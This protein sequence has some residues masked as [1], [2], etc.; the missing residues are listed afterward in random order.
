MN[1]TAKVNEKKFP[2]HVIKV[3]RADDGCTAEVRSD[4]IVYHVSSVASGA[5]AFFGRA[6]STK[7]SYFRVT[8]GGPTQTTTPKTRFFSSLKTTTRKERSISVFAKIDSEEV[9]GKK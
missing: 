2:V 6:K 1:A 9:E 3:K 8:S 5:C 4:T 7:P